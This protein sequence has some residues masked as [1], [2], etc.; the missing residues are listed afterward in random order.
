MLPPSTTTTSYSRAWAL[1]TARRAMQA[2]CTCA[3]RLDVGDLRPAIRDR[4]VLTGDSLGGFSQHYEC[5]QPHAAEHYTQRLP[6]HALRR[7]EG[8]WRRQ[9]HRVHTGATPVPHASS[10]TYSP[11]IILPPSPMLTSPPRTPSQRR[12]TTV[13]PRSSYVCP[14]TRSSASTSHSYFASI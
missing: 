11:L 12:P 1:S 6:R 2:H 10:P 13:P 4:L 14:T 5:A 3:T 9:R 7:Q 8:L